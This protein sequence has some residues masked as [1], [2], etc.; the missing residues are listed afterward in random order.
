MPTVE[1]LVTTTKVGADFCLSFS[2]RPSALLIICNQL[3]GV[4]T[5]ALSL[6]KDDI[7]AITMDGFGQFSI[8][9]E[10]LNRGN[11]SLLRFSVLDPPPLVP[12]GTLPGSGELFLNF[13]V[14][15]ITLLSLVPP[16]VD[17]SNVVRELF[18]VLLGSWECR[19]NNTF[20]E[21]S[22]VTEL[23][24]CGKHVVAVKV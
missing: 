1:R 6:Y 23:S 21:D 7:L 12:I 11:N 9:E 24:D 19:V 17:M 5:P 16:G 3:G 13:K 18:T 8:S 2:N 20:G 10:F 22:A 14:N 4:P 15:N